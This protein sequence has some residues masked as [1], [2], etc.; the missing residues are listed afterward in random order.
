[1]IR[2]DFAFGVNQEFCEIPWNLLCLALLCIKELRV[3]TQILV[4]LTTLGAIDVSFL[5]HHEFS[6]VELTS[7]SLDLIIATRF[8]FHELIAG[9]CQDL[10]TLVPILLVHSHHLSIGLVSEASLAGHV[11]NHDALFALKDFS[12]LC[13][14]FSIDVYRWL[15]EQGLAFSLGKLFLA[16]L[17][18]SLCY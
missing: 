6:T 7:E 4:D 13:D 2:N 17:E 12:Q 5:K 14:S 11:D 9:E 8:L 18:D 3:T 10:K 16:V 1:M 15:I